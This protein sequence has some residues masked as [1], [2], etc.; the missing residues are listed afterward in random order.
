MGPLQLVHALQAIGYLNKGQADNLR[1]LTR[2]GSHGYEMLYK[3][4]KRI[5]EQ[6]PDIYLTAKTYHR[7]TRGATKL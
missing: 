5:R 2:L 3:F 6:E 1:S 7:I 4:R